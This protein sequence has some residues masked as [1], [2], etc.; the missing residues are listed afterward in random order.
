MWPVGIMLYILVVAFV[1]TQIEQQLHGGG[2]LVMSMFIVLPVLVW[3]VRDMW[4]D[5]KEKVERE[6]KEM[7]RTLKG[8][9]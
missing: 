4:R 5:A 3:L 1:S 2:A 7:M 8:S 9:D 6:N